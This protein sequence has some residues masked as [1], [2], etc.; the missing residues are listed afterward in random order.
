MKFVLALVMTSTIAS[1][2]EPTGQQ[3]CASFGDLAETIMQNRQ[4][5]VPMSKMMDA[6]DLE[7]ARAIIL[8]A[9]KLPRFSS[10]DYQEKQTADFRNEVELECYKHMGK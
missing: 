5:G 4:N 7:L 6:T 1:A 10:E 2:Q 9:Y 3:L 8:D